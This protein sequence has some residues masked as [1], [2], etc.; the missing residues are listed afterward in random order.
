M[1]IGAARGRWQGLPLE[2]AGRRLGPSRVASLRRSFDKQWD[3][4]SNCGQ[5]DKRIIGDD[6]DQL[7]YRI[8]SPEAPIA[9][10]LPPSF[11]LVHRLL[12]TS[13]FYN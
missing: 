8:S 1:N 11:G 7:G 6:A 9:Y 4:N 10:L 5:T 3:N 12:H 13:F 2:C